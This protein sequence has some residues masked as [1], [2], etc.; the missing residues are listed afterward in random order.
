MKLLIAND[1]P[2][3]A[4]CKDHPLAGRWTNHREFHAGG[5]LLVI[6]YRRGDTIVFARIGTHT[7]LFG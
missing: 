5:D 7:E 2:L 1:G 6:Y 3:P 4:E